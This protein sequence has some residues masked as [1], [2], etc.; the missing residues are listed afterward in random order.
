[1]IAAV[2][3]LISKRKITSPYVLLDGALKSVFEQLLYETYPE[4]QFAADVRYPFRHLE[5]DGI[6]TLD[7]LP[8]SIG[9]LTVARTLGA[10]A[11]EL[12]KHVAC[13]R[14]DADVFKILS[15]SAEARLSV[16]SQLATRYLRPESA[17]VMLRLLGDYSTPIPRGVSRAED[18]L[19]ERGIEELLFRNWR[20]TA[21]YKELGIELA[22]REQHGLPGRQVLTPVNA[23][24]LLGFRESQREWW[25]IELKRGRPADA[26]V[27]QISRYL[28]WLMED[29]R[30]R[31]ETVVGAI[32]AG[33]VDPKLRYAVRANE[34]LSLWT[35]DDDLSLARIP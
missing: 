24:D 27:G 16:L 14:M 17:A 32:V 22:S 1:L 4:W 33:S 31:G 25:V 5:S 9:A 20:A 13:A 11:R 23:I 7:A 26:V 2:V 18:G 29:R 12:L 8:Q 3:V 6:W 28:A 34:R 30:S 21:F 35:Y 10:R 15:E 19:T